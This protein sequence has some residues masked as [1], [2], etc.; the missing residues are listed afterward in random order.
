MPLELLEHFT[1]RCRDMERSRDFY[2]DVL[3][4][5]VG[6]R[7]PL[8]FDGYWLYCGDTPAV[9]LVKT[10]DPTA[11]ASSARLVGKD[12]AMLPPGPRTGALDHLAFR[13]SDH[14]A[15][16]KKLDGLKVRYEHNV[17]AGGR[18]HQL[19]LQD[20]DGLIIELNFPSRP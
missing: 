20:P 6:P 14:G 1:I 4:F 7:P 2:R 8:G 15:M 11:L 18:L 12:L 5:D 10:D 17:G 9:H 16:M 3:G 19:F 13:G